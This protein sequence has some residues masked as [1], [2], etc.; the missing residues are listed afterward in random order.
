MAENRLKIVSVENGNDS[1][2]K[3][4][5]APEARREEAQAK[6]ER[7]WLLDPEQ[8]NPLR[9]CVNR[10]RIQRTWTAITQTGDL[11]EKKVADLGCGKGILTL[12]MRDAG[13]QV[14]A[15]DVAS[16]AFKQLLQKSDL[17]HIKL[18]QDWVPKTAL[19][20]DTY[21]L[22]LSTDLIAELSPNDFRLY[23][24]EL[25]RLIKPKGHVIVS[26]PLD[27]KAEDA[28]ERFYK[29]AETEFVMSTWIFSYHRLHIRMSDFFGA[30]KRFKRAGGNKDDRHQQ[31]IK[32]KGFS[33]SWFKFNSQPVLA[34]LW[35]I[36][37]FILQ[38][39]NYL[40]DQSTGFMIFLEKVSRFVYAEAGISH[41]IFVGERK[42]I[43]VPEPSPILGK[44]KVR[45]W[46]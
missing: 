1:P 21:D 44:E 28:L 9:D 37:A 23:F 45:K 10:E 24:S 20:D 5:R 13:A 3:P 19:L 29:L 4:S 7:L 39:V 2:K 26:T 8:F 22:V 40:L 42:P 36:V 15:L 34:S 25:A 30:A 16:N 35:G 32:R 38:P 18:I 27:I 6:Y 12:K 17:T 31:L 41:A 14:D 11:K 43:I 33:H 46:E